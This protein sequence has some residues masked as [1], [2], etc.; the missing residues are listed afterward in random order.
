[1]VLRLDSIAYSFSPEIAVGA[2]LSR[3]T[4]RKG[5][6]PEAPRC[7]H[8]RANPDTGRQHALLTGRSPM[9]LVSRNQQT[10]RS[11]AI[12]AE[13]TDKGVVCHND[14]GYDHRCFFAIP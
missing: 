3:P 6:N 4:H 11:Y 2:L 9:A 12:A 10:A 1:M 7:P 5:D 13:E 8:S 14:D